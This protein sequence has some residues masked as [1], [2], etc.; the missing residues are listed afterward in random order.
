MAKLKDLKVVIGLSKK[1]L[2]KLN[3]DLRQ[4]KSTFKKNFGEIQSRVAGVGKAMTASITAPLVLMGAQSLKAFNIQAK[5]IAQVEA[6]LKSTGNQ[7][8]LTSKQLQQLASNL[9][10]KTIFGDEEILQGATAQLLTFTNIA[11]EQFART[12]SVALDLA[13]RLDGDLKS[14][15]IQL[16]KALNDPVKNLSALSRAGI[17]FSDEQKEVINSLAETGRLAEAQTLILNELEKQY[18]GSAEAAAKAG[19]GP[20]KQLQNSIGDLSEQFG[21]LIAEVL[22]PIIP[23]VTAVVNS[24]SNLSIGTKKTVLAIAAMLGAAGPIAMA[25]AAL[26]PVIAALSGPV[27]L[28]GLAVAGLA[29]LVVKNFAVIEPAI[30]EVVNGMIAFQNKTKIIGVVFSVLETYLV[31][32]FK[33]VKG[34]FSALLDIVSSFGTAVQL[35]LSGKFAEAGDVIVQAF[36]RSAENAHALGKEMSE[37]MVKGIN[38]ALNAEDIELLEAGAI[39]DLANGIVSD[40]SKFFKSGGAAPVEVPIEPT[41]SQRLANLTLA[42]VVQDEEE[43]VFDEEEQRRIQEH[44]KGL[45]RVALAA[46][47]TGKA[48]NFMGDM[49]N[50]AFDNIKDKSQGFHEVIKAMLES[51]LKRA[52]ALAATFAAI[53]LFTGGAAGA[54][55]ATG[56]KSFGG[57]MMGGLGVPQMADGGMFTGASLAMVGEGA[58]TSAINPEVVAPLDKL[59]DMMGGGNVTVTGRLD[60]RDILISSERAGFD[61]NRV[62]GF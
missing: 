10:R 59:R 4:T 47:M 36:A 61:R 60:G 24:F 58:G 40:V 37:N 7:V 53:S 55:K 15:S 62:R 54:L 51:L 8:G 5:A 39:S 29:A 30:I 21:A 22:M 49:V 23:K 14:A 56:A 52:I 17:Q 31:G 38:D 28:I 13:T 34:G 2:T 25:V 45:K 1:G 46:G 27:V 44:E 9:Q 16:G 50:A 42:E 19:T 48:F 18:G 35:V 33:F 6:G 26:M 3:S 11:G 41:I 20:F 57:F 43:P 12:Q 32:W